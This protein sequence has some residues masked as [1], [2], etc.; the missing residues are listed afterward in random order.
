MILQNIKKFFENKKHR[1]ILTI[2]GPIIAAAVCVVLVFVLQSPSASGVEAPDIVDLEVGAEDESPQNDNDLF[3]NA[4]ASGEF[5][6]T[7]LGLTADAG[8][9]YV[10]DTVF[11]GDSN[12]AGMIQSTNVTNVSLTNGIGV[13][14][15]GISHVTSL[16]CA[17]FSGMSAV[18][19]PEAVKI[20]QP[21]RI[22]I[23]FGTNDYYMKPEKFAE[24]YS[25]AIDAIKE[26]YPYSDIIIG[27]IFPITY[28]CSYL[29]VSMPTI[30]KFNFELVK[31]AKEKDLHFLNW[32]EALKD[33]VDGF[34]RPEYMAGDGVHLSKKGMEKIFEYF[35]THKLDSED[36]RPK[37]L[38][39]VPAR[40]P[41]PFGLLGVGL[42][43]E[44][45]EPEPLIENLVTV[46]VYAG[47]GGSV[48]G[49]GTFTVAPGSTVGPFTAQ[50]SPG[51]VFIGWEGVGGGAT[52]SYTVP[53]DAA[54]G[55]SF[56]IVAIFELDETPDPPEQPP[57]KP[58]DKPP[59]VVPP[60]EPEEPEGE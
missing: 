3:A 16:K 35:R 6:D 60:D 19:V 46:S 26:A 59:P 52:I 2:G 9:S 50:A 12:T 15:M 13:V 28:N 8:V 25:K 51:Y 45:D 17:K 53:T 43:T 14:S 54:P 38:K 11:I 23:N 22:V 30:E 37:P 58:P 39:P 18:T 31:L 4:L 47:V 24:T 48:T 44:S 36:K 29:T 57:E 33:P 27:S 20:M 34:C 55:S 10:K 56:A 1:K 40:E 21:R 5:D 7:V 32:S 41:N 42:S 49:G